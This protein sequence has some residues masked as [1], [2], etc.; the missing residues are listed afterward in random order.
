MYG[1]VPVNHSNG[2]IPEKLPSW[3]E[4]IFCEI[5]KL[6]VFSTGPNHVLLN[7]YLNGQGIGPHRDGPLYHNTAAVLSLGGSAVIE[8]LN[9][10]TVSHSLFLEGRSLLLFMDSA[11]DSL[12]HQI[13]DIKQDELHKDICNL[14]LL[15]GKKEGDTIPRGNSRL[16]LTMRTVVQVSGGSDFSERAITPEEKHEMIRREAFFYKS[17]S[18]NN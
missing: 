15:D 9:Q 4:V 7:E 13:Q 12:L 6:G 11:Y 2:M 14:H 17:I 10:N 3:L 8:F 16:S 5:R 1:G 18:E